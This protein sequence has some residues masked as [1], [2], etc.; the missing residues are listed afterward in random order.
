M[1]FRA[2]RGAS[3]KQ[4][5]SKAMSLE[6]LNPSACAHQ[7]VVRL[8]T[9]NMG[10]QVIGE[11]WKCDQCPREFEARE[12]GA[13]RPSEDALAT[14]R[15]LHDSIMPHDPVCPYTAGQSCDCIEDRARNIERVAFHLDAFSDHRMAEMAKAVENAP[16]GG[17]VSVSRNEMRLLGSLTRSL[18]R[19]PMPKSR[20]QK[21]DDTGVLTT[22]HHGDD[23][24]ELDTSY[25]PCPVCRSPEVPHA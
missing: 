17:M 2:G 13:L 4:R 25:D 1:V 24:A 7:R 5:S 22:F 9:Y 23:G 19:N 6:Q 10:G 11:Y 3:I 8:N 18:V 12:F 20:C 16:T 21:C 14:A 15:T